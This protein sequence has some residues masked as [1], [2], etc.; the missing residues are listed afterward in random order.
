MKK[1]FTLVELLV[2]IVLL[3]LVIVITATSGFGA[4]N[5]TKKGIDK[6]EEDN[7]LEAARTFLVDVDNGL[8]DETS[9]YCNITLYIN[10]ES[11]VPVSYIKENYMSSNADHCDGS[12]EL[13]LKIIKDGNGN[14]TDYIAK[15]ANDE[16]I[17]TN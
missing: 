3:G 2:V 9:P 1:G 17:C 8:C 10:T 16:A 14:T 4:F 12:K 6:I 13:T 5:K 7:L 15:K 11:T